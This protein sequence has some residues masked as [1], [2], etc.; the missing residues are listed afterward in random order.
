M[1]DIQA[2]STDEAFSAQKQRRAKLMGKRKQRL[3][4]G[5]ACDHAAEILQAIKIV[6]ERGDK[7]TLRDDV[8]IEGESSV[9][10]ETKESAIVSAH[11]DDVAPTTERTP[12]S[13]GEAVPQNVVVD[14]N[15]EIDDHVATVLP[16]ADVPTECQT[17]SGDSQAM[18]DIQAVT[19]DGA[20]SPQKQRSAKL[21]GKRKQRLA[22]GPA[23]DHAAEIF[24]AIKIVNERGDKTTSRDD[25]QIEGDSLV[26]QKTVESAMVSAQEDDVAPITELT[27]TSTV[28]AVPQNVVVDQNVEIDDHVPTALPTADVLTECQ[29]TSGDSQASDKTEVPSSF[30]P[31][32]SLDFLSENH[33]VFPL[34]RD[35]PGF[36]QE[37]GSQC[38]P[39]SF[40]QSTA[41][42]QDI[43][44]VDENTPSSTCE[45]SAVTSPRYPTE[46]SLSSQNGDEVVVNMLRQKVKCPSL[47]FDDLLT[48]NCGHSVSN[49]NSLLEIGRGSYGRVLLARHRKTS[50]PVAI[51]E[52]FR[53]NNHASPGELVDE[54]KET[55]RRANKE[56][57]VHH[58]LSDSPYFPRFLGTL[59][60]GNDLCLG[61]QFVGDSETGLSYPLLNPPPLSTKDGLHIAE[62]VVKGMMELHENGL[63]H[64]D[65]KSDNVLLERRGGRYRGVIIDFGMVSSMTSPLQMSGLPEAVKFAYLQGDEADYL[66]PEIVLDEEQTSVHSEIFSLGV[67]LT[68]IAQVLDDSRSP[69]VQEL[70]SLGMRCRIRNPES[71]PSLTT[72]LKEISEL[73][74]RFKRPPFWKRLFR[75]LRK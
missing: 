18:S 37:T 38:T 42:E 41:P 60:N 68:D 28:K 47:I 35:I 26:V 52:P 75:K 2:V 54:L 22:L 20:L 44:S 13:T 4:L 9:V 23:C 30:P 64:N 74:R 49:M 65:M 31:A 8:Q 1:S 3:A 61:V 50:I 72:I 16:T 48:F 25:V 34:L 24:Q 40:R 58:L 36:N 7:T 57:L 63:L 73:K 19:T 70:S 33:E 53:S 71:R 59:D 27:T 32:T 11:G 17:T 5:P 69:T 21:M 56:A 62:D 67:I 66:A 46:S 51:K 55:R 39:A 6:N 45:N 29:T 43:H 14:Q 15:V 10:Q 12:A